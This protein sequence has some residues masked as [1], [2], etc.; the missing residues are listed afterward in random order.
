VAPKVGVSVKWARWS[1]KKVVCSLA[2]TQ[3]PPIRPAQRNIPRAACSPWT[4]ESRMI[5][6]DHR[7]TALRGNCTPRNW[8]AGV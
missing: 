5:S 4:V 3:F 7:L 6:V 8:D 1:V 2:I